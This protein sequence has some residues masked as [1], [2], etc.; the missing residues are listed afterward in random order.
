MVAALVA[1]GLFMKNAAEKSKR[2]KKGL[3]QHPKVRS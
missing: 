2:R 3:K 1:A